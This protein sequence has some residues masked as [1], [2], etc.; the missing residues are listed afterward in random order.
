MG[1]DHIDVE[2]DQLRKQRRQPVIMA[3]SPAVF[4]PNIPSL[5]I[6]E[7]AQ[8][9]AKRL[10]AFGQTVGGGQTQKSDAKDLGR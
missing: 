2:I 3:V 9:R 8:A 5:L 1:D 4:D 6:T 10:G 7:I